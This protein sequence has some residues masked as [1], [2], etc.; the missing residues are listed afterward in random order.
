MFHHNDTQG[1]T[2]RQHLTTLQEN[3]ESKDWLC[4]L[5]EMARSGTPIAQVH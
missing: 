4:N 3:G 1:Q 5:V 2:L